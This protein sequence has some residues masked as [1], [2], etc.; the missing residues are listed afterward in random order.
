MQ[1]SKPCRRSPFRRKDKNFA[2]LLSD[3]PPSCPSSRKR[4]ESCTLHKRRPQSARDI[5]VS[6]SRSLTDLSRSSSPF[7]RPRS[8]SWCTILASNASTPKNIQPDTIPK[9]LS[10]WF[11]A[12]WQ[13]VLLLVAAIAALLTLILL[14]CQSLTAVSPATEVTTNDAVTIEWLEDMLLQHARKP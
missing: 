12:N 11:K 8:D 7:T 13:A 14:C 1:R 5:H 2:F 3:D 6:E 4:A 10:G 9:N